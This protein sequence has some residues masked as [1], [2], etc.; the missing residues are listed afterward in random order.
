[1]KMKLVLMLAVLAAV[2]CAQQP[3]QVS[4]WIDAIEQDHAV[5]FVSDGT[6]GTRP[7]VVPLDELPEYIRE[8]DHLVEGRVDTHSTHQMRRSIEQLHDELFEEDV[9]LIDLGEDP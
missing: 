9:R 4:G 6:G 7:L 1:M 8:G 5:V 3:V 2:M